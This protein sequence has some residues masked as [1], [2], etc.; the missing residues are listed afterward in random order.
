VLKM[1]DKFDPLTTLREE[2]SPGPGDP[3]P[4]HH[5]RSINLD[6]KNYLLGQ[7]RV[8]LEK[9]PEMKT[10]E[11]KTFLLTGHQKYNLALLSQRTLLRFI[12]TNVS[13]VK[14]TT[15]L[16]ETGL[17]PLNPSKLTVEASQKTVEVS[18]KKVGEK[19]VGEA[20][21]CN[22]KY[23][24]S[25]ELQQ[26]IISENPAHSIAFTKS[27]RNNTQLLLD[28]F[29]LKKKKGPYLQSGG[30]AISWKCVDDGCRFTAST[31][32]GRLKCREVHNHPA[33]P[34]LYIKKVVRSQL[35]ENIA[36]ERDK[37]QSQP[38][39]GLLQNMVESTE[40]G[41]SQ[42]L[43]KQND[44]LRQFARR[45]K[46]KIAQNTKSSQ[47]KETQSGEEG[48]N[49]EV[50]DTEFISCDVKLEEFDDNFAV[51]VESEESPGQESFIAEEN[52][53]VEDFAEPSYLDYS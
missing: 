5:S 48:L 36:I 45:F 34:E 12:S 14:E 52:I 2:K 23:L 51:K 29:I 39:S 19:T 1:T 53:K 26:L 24:V 28:D 10:H 42:V 41:V 20:V 15:N 49:S 50:K 13:H 18:E 22:P 43:N 46:R 8:A 32:E 3:P 33:H 35:R 40:E 11:V 38:V 27:Q 37:W 44:A 6:C 47:A 31:W 17:S 25:E 21:I 4:V 30:R 7:I 9:W 16:A